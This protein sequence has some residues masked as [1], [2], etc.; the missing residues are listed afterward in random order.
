[1]FEGSFIMSLLFKLYDNEGN[2]NIKRD[3]YT[4]SNIR[5][6]IFLSQKKKILIII[7]HKKFNS[8]Y[9]GAPII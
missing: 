8:I 2:E 1:M 5:I 9:L 7:L 6:P 3:E 4:E